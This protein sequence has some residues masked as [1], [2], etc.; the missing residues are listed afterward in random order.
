MIIFRLQ[1]NRTLAR[2]VIRRRFI[3]EVILG[4][5]KWD[6]RMWWTKWHNDTHF[7]PPST[8]VSPVSITPPM[9]VLSSPWYYS[10]SGEAH[11]F[12]KCIKLFS[13]MLFIYP[14]NPMATVCTIAFYIQKPYILTTEYSFT[15]RMT[16]TKEVFPCIKCVC[17]A[18]SLRGANW[19][20]TY[21]AN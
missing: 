15:L 19:I 4:R 12:K 5:S 9:S 20:C 13:F 2:A 16:R 18:C 6:T 14:W 17:A 1:K 21:S 7:F 8:S 3:A 11:D 10:L